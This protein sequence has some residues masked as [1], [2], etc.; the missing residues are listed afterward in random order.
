VLVGEGFVRR[1]RGGY[2]R[3]V[4][5][6]E[7]A[8]GTLTRGDLVLRAQ[9]GDHDAFA[10]LA[11]SATNRLYGIALRILSDVHL[12][13]DAVQD[14]LIDAWRDLRALR[15]PALFDA[16]ATR[17]LIRNCYR[18]AKRARTA[19]QVTVTRH[20]ETTNPTVEI[21]DRDRIEGAFRRLPPDHRVVIV[22]RHYLDWE[23]AEIADALGLAP[24]T[25][26]SRLHYAL[27]GLRAALEADERASLSV[28]ERRR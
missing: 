24:G 18:E 1:Q 20:E 27:A 16:W 21:D 13:E 28:E 4:V 5:P 12:A 23:P 19:R 26:R 9:G 17:I 8:S 3:V 6:D 7:A 15:D 14:S 11:R 25:V 10:V 2:S 22:L